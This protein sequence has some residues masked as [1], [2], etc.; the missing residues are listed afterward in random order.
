M[1][2]IKCNLDNIRSALVN[3]GGFS[4]DIFTATLS[5]TGQ[6]SSRLCRFSTLNA[7][8]ECLVHE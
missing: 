3:A 1:P 2:I 5:G 6:P 4:T 7:T 8:A